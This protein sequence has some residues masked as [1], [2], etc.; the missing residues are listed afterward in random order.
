[1]EQFVCSECGAETPKWEGRCPTC[2]A[3]NSLKE[4]ARIVG[5]SSKKSI[6]IPGEKQ[7]AIKLEDI[8]DAVLTRTKTGIGEFDVV[9]GGGIVSGM[10]GL[11]GG[12]PGIGKSTLMMQVADRVPGTLYVSGEESLQQIKLRAGRLS[13]KSDSLHLLCSTDA[14]AVTEEILRLKPPLVIIDSIQSIGGALEGSSAGSVSQVREVTGLLVR[15]AKTT[16]TAIML[17]GH[18]TKDGSVAGPK[19]I[20]HMVDTV[21]YFE[22]DLPYRMLRAVKNRF[23][24]TNEIGIFEMRADGLA[25]VKN[26]SVLF[27]EHFQPNPGIAVGCVL[28][29][30]RPFLVEAQTLV[31]AANY[32]TS[33]RVS[34]GY[35]SKKLAVML[36]VL[37][38]FLSIS[39]RQN[40]I[41]VNL[42]GGIRS[43]DTSLDLAVM[44]S[45]LSSAR[46]VVLPP[47]TLFLGEVGLSGEIRPVSQYEK[48][49]NEAAKHGYEQV[50]VAKNAH[51][52]I[53]GAKL[54]RIGHIADLY[55]LLFS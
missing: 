14:N 1:M 47:K 23:G 44:A 53:K 28:E 42:I 32:G 3:W 49:I 20:E 22:G 11:I 4:T 51:S 26:P 54:Q 16:G 5:K 19:I 48:R 31:T 25:E 34:I 41:F 27:V 8:D 17:I 38:K 10:A 24:S 39:L 55:S 30:S 15:L 18:V 21:L 29:G 7:K 52:G 2:G 12:D 45:V 36:A 13:V 37:E 33:Q 43:G 46:E 40:D 6:S 9:L 50:Y 35:D